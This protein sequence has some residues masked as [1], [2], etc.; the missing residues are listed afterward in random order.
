MSR[1]TFS[2][3]VRESKDTV[4][5]TFGRMNPPT[6]GHEKL[7]DKMSEAAGPFPYRVYLSRSNDT[8]KN[9]LLF[10]DK[11][12]FA[13]KAFPKHGRNICNDKSVRNILEAASALHD[14]GYKK[15]VCMVGADRVQEFS[16]RL[17]LYNGKE[18]R[19]GY[20][21]FESIKVRSAGKRSS[22][23]NSVE[24][25]SATTLREAAETSDF[26]TFSQG[27]PKTLTNEDAK[28][29]FN[30][31][32]IGMNLAEEKSFRSHIK[33]GK[34]SPIR[35]KYIAGELFEIGDEVV[36]KETQEVAHLAVLGANYVI[37]ETSDGKRVRKWLDDVE[38][39]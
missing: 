1:L 22:A 26:V 2:E 20:Y 36:I 6:L 33:L 28:R 39:L 9:P 35:E 24:A 37:V 13:R 18:G 11:L 10:E 32:R 21:M 14:D 34:T 3:F 16:E 7:L 25:A 4:Y 5:F 27:L 17:K 38:K 29:L 12:K 23:G 19:H 8:K 15:I 30:K 31:I